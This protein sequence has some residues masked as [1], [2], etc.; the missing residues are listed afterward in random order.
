MKPKSCIATARANTQPS[1]QELAAKENCIR[2][3]STG[4]FTVEEIARK[5]YRGSS[6]PENDEEERHPLTGDVTGAGHSAKLWRSWLRR[7]EGWCNKPASAV[8]PPH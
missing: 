6:I 8:T 5:T 2:L 3:Y 7:V 1:P 4:R